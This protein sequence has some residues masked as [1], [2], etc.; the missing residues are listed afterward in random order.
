MPDKYHNTAQQ[1]ILK[2]MLALA[3]HEVEGLKPT[4]L[5][6][7]LNV[8]AANITRDLENL[9]I[10]GLAE[11]L[12]SGAW[13]LAPKLVQVSISYSSNLDKARRKLDEVTNR[14]SRTPR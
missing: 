10:A 7:G 13:R 3:G 6:K 4:A 2:V 11:K 5:A 12:E 1:R 14:Y 8:P 9:L